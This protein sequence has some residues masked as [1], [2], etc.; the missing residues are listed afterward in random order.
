MVLVAR[1][2]PVSAGM[3]ADGPPDIGD[4]IVMDGIAERWGAHYRLVFTEGKYQAY[5]LIP[6]TAD[7]PD[8]LD[9]AIRADF[10]RQNAR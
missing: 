1:R 8:G 7:T 4:A 9:S 10:S 2:Y 3:A 5:R 6:L